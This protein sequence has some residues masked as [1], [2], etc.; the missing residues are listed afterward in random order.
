MNDF[1]KQDEELIATFLENAL[2]D[3]QTVDGLPDHLRAEAASRLAMARSIAGTSSGSD[4]RAFDRIA[5]RFGFDRPDSVNVDGRR[6]KSCRMDAEL[7]LTEFAANLRGAG[8]DVSPGDLLK[9]QRLPSLPVDRHIAT[10]ISA[11]LNVPVS[12]FESFTSELSEAQQ[13]MS[14]PEF[15]RMVTDWCVEYDRD[16]M[17]TTREVARQLLNAGY[18]ASGV[19]SE[20]LRAIVSQILEGLE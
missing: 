12:D 14:S 20:N 17:T 9:W 18:R 10:A 8:V 19:S 4:Q 16:P 11:V 1:T 6:I 15:E 13:F 7:D 3:E 5:H 2:A